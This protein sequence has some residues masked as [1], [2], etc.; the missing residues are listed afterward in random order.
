[1]A[2]EKA[3]EGQSLEAAPS[4]AALVVTQP[5]K[6]ESLLDTINLLNTVS[7]RIG[8]DKSGDMGSGGGT[9]QGDDDAGTTQQSARD[10]AIANLP[11]MPV[12][13]KKLEGHIRSE[14]KKLR[15][16][17]RKNRI[18]AT[19]PGSAY[20]LQD[21]YARMRQLNGVLTELLGA[22]IDVVKR[23]YVRIFID[24]QSVF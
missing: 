1:M 6:L 2:T 12:M 22:S 7:E 11:A 16:E 4:S 21:I 18:R 13:Q 9:T 14:V 15:K 24:K 10:I 3:N 8:E 23:L 5:Q 19:K 17:V 20:K